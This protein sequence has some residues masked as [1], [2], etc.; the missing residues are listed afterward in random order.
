MLISG[1]KNAKDTVPIFSFN[2]TLFLHSSFECK[3][4]WTNFHSFTFELF[5]E[6]SFSLFWDSEELFKN[7]SKIFIDFIRFLISKICIF[8]KSLFDISNCFC[9][10]RH[11]LI[12]DFSLRRHELISLRYE[13]LVR[14]IMSRIGIETCLA[15]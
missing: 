7:H 4:L 6:E 15:D 11:E 10:G 14:L 5:F 3:K 9:N 13:A 8:S 1:E 12:R 2:L